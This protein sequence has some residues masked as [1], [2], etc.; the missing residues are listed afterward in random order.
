MY[1]DDYL[2][3]LIISVGCYND[4]FF[5]LQVFDENK[6]EVGLVLFGTDETKNRLA[7]DGQYQNITVRRH[8]MIP[9]FELL[10]EIQN[11]L[12]PGGQQADCIPDVIVPQ[13]LKFSA[14]FNFTLFVYVYETLDFFIRA[15]CSCCVHGSPAARN[16]VRLL[17]SYSCFDLLLI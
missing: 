7:K 14:L 12:Q 1:Y 8:L 13:E 6:D 2:L 9:D 5:I 3:L 15:R 17:F 11:E 4:T 16:H 10:E